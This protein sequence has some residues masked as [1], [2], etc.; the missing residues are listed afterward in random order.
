MIWTH[1]LGGSRHVALPRAATSQ[2]AVNHVDVEID[3][4][5]VAGLTAILV[6]EVRT[7]DGGVTITPKLRNITDAN[8]TALG[9][10]ATGTDADYSGTNQQQEIVV[11]FASGVKKY[12]LQ[13]TPSADTHDTFV[14]GYLRLED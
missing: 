8:N 1:Y 6:V 12:R 3:S 2:D 9:A 4:A 10:A 5:L 13:G 11:T 14:I 7:L